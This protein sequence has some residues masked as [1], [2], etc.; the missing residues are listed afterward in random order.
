MLI[1]SVKNQKVKDWK[2]LQS[3]KGREKASA[4][5]IEGPHIV[6]EAAKANALV[7]EVIL[8]EGSE[9]EVNLFKDQP[10]VYTVTE[11]VMKEITATETPQGIIAVCEMT[12]SVIEDK[13]KFILLDAI[14]DPGNL[15][16]IIRTAHSAGYDGVLLGNGTVDLY[17]SKVLRSTQGSLFHI[18]I[19]KVDLQEAVQDFNNAGLSIYA[20]EVSGGTPYNQLQ[21]PEH[22]AIIMGNE[23]NGV[24][25]DLQEL[26]HEKVYIP[27]YGGAE[28][29]NVAVAAGILMYGLLPS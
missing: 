29:L 23:A 19:K 24:S 18:P 15:G 12:E 2:K 26:A 9:F 7:T 28:S 10:K 1:E 27:I 11:K 17:N 6:E 22:F 16:T 3:K 14:Q 21:G 25:K 4:F 20:T 5:L 13:G 8:S